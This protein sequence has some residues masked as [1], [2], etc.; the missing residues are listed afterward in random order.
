MIILGIICLVLGWLLGL[1]I[2]WIIGVVLLVI[3]LILLAL[4]F[5][6]GAVAGGGPSPW[7][8]RRYY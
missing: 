5:T 8:R 3:G 1:S 4:S 7:Y 2:L 6:G